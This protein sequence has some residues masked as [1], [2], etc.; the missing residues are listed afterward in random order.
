[1][2]KSSI[3]IW[4]AIPVL[5][6]IGQFA[7]AQT[8]PT[9]AD[10]MNLPQNPVDADNTKSNR[11]DPSNMNQTADKQPNNAT[12]MELTQTIRRSVTADKNLSTY[13]H[14]VKIV[15][16]NGTVTLNGVVRSDGEKAE[17]GRKAAAVVGT[18][19]VVNELKVT[20]TK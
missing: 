1:M 3:P 14:N 10:S 4:F 9:A 17:V 18:D 12:D 6:L 5:G 13:A 7:V 2:A 15:T 11:N 19:H 16:A 8:S 20:S